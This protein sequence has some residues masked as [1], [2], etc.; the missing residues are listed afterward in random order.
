MS[1]PDPYNRGG[2]YAFIFSMAFSL[3]FFV[4]VGVIYPGINLREVPEPDAKQATDSAQ[5][6]AP[7]GVDISKV[8]NPWASSDDMIAH[9]KVIYQNNCTIC[10]GATGVGDG[11]AG[12]SLVPP[13]RNLV[14]GKWKRGSGTEIDMFN[15][16]KD[17]L[18]GTSMA[19][20]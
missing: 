3:L 20:F 15:T 14:E 7:A 12:K 10:H 1:T 6:A 5:A 4:Y 17:G 13:P 19:P 11:P 18:P 16:I 9:G 8:T 2:F